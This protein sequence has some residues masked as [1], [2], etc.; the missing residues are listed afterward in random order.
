MSEAK[1]LISVALV[2]A[3]ITFLGYRFTERPVW[4]SNRSLGSSINFLEGNLTSGSAT[5]STTR[6]LLLPANS[7][8]QYAIFTN[9]GADSPVYLHLTSASTTVSTS[10]G[11]RLNVSGGSYEILP[12]NLYTGEVWIIS[13]TSTP[14]RVLTVEK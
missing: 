2:I 10:T 7:G 14:Q 5:A 1:K 12:G 9:D 6:K 4:E 3:A 13:N 11:I 8:R